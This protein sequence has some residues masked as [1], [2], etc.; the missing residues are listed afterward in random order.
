MELA[1]YVDW[2]MLLF[3]ISG[4]VFGLYVGRK[5]SDERIDTAIETTID[6]LIKNNFVKWKRN[7]DGDVELI[8][9]DE[10]DF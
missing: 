6:T 1:F 7:E 8:K 3:Y 9:L 5:L 4:T 2:Y 10:K